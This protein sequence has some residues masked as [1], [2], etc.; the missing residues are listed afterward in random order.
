MGMKVKIHPLNMALQAQRLKALFPNSEINF[1]SQVLN[2]RCVITPSPL[3]RE[4]QIKLVLGRGEQPNVYIESPLL[5]LYPEKNSLPHV[6]S[7]KKQWLCLYY[8]KVKQWNSGMYLADTVV[9]WISEW[10]MHYELWLC[11]GIWHGGGIHDEKKVENLKE[12]LI[13]GNKGRS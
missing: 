3:S 10:L 1:N 9:P 13:E 7:T 5:E 8:K 4:Y 2:W 6:Y 12:E 11:T